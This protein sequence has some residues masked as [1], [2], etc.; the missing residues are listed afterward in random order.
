MLD[1]PDGG[2]RRP[3][4]ALPERAALLALMDRNMVA[5]YC[6]DTRATPGGEVTELAGLVL[7]STPRGTVVSNMAIVTGPVDVPAVREA[8]G[9]VFRGPGRPFSVWTRAHAD[10][11][12]ERELRQA[13]FTAFHEE[14]AMVLAPRKAEPR[15]APPEIAIRPVIDEAGR[16]AYGRVMAQAYSVYGTPPESTL[17]RFAA[18]A[19]V[20]GPERRAFLAYKGGRA[21]AGAML[22]MAHEVGAVNWVGTLPEEFGRGYGAAV[23]WAVVR[24]GL[25]RGARFLNLQASPMGASL[26][27]RLGFSTPTHYRVFVAHE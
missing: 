19:S 18:L 22:Y 27:R 14:P 3:A 4:M 21:V 7:C 12:L 9:R 10:A 8:T 13:G 15:A 17:E 6:A 1:N 26:Y 23:V 20:A 16:E 24:E 25:E 2:V 11:C 5:M